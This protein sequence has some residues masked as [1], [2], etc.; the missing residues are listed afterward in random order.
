MTVELRRVGNADHAKQAVAIQMEAP[1]SAFDVVMEVPPPGCWTFTLQAGE[2]Y[3][4]VSL[5]VPAAR[6]WGVRSLGGDRE[7]RDPALATALLRSLNDCCVPLPEARPHLN[8]QLVFARGDNDD[9]IPVAIAPTVDGEPGVL[10]VPASFYD[11]DCARQGS[12]AAPLNGEAEAELRRRGWLEGERLVRWLALANEPGPRCERWRTAPEGAIDPAAADAF[13]RADLARQEERR[14]AEHARMEAEQARH[15]GE[16]RAA[17]LA[18]PRPAASPRSEVNATIRWEEDPAVASPI[19]IFLPVR[20]HV[21]RFEFSGSVDRSTVT[22]RLGPPGYFFGDAPSE[23]GSQR[24]VNLLFE[25]IDGR[26]GR[27]RVP[28]PLPNGTRAA[29]LD[30]GDVRDATGVPLRRAHLRFGLADHRATVWKVSTDPNRAPEMVLRVDDWIEPRSVSPDG[31][32]ALFVRQRFTGFAHTSWRIPYLFDLRTGERCAYPAA[33]IAAPYWPDDGGPPWINQMLRLGPG[34]GTSPLPEPPAIAGGGRVIEMA[35]DPRGRYL[36]AVA[37]DS[38]RPEPPRGDLVLID[39]KSGAQSRYAGIVGLGFNLYFNAPTAGL[40]WSR[41]GRRLAVYSEVRL[42]A[43]APDVTQREVWLLEPGASSPLPGE[44]PGWRR[45][46]PAS[47]DWFSGVDWSPDGRMLSAGSRGVIDLDGRV[48]RPGLSGFWSPDG[49]WMVQGVEA[50]RFMLWNLE[51]GEGRG[52]TI[53]SGPRPGPVYPQF[54]GWSN[55][56][57]MYYG[58]LETVPPPDARG[59]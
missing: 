35:R 52:V 27:V 11:G 13:I 12:V 25:W 34:G 7:L 15:E 29:T 48:L 22:P 4:R 36:A 40:A 21:F 44:P 30:L 47:E 2:R 8:A 49:R 28:Y 23:S 37:T 50:G 46:L 43:S 6:P 5:R 56:G 20:P 58:E 1:A 41:D 38:P 10:V 55:D 3:N 31:R 42:S 45:F 51:T 18:P 57:F 59:R 24:L 33:E 54:L 39:L 9:V 14:Q 16:R 17:Q 26:H 19:D 53:Q 32:R